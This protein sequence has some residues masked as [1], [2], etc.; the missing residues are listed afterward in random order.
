VYAGSGEECQLPRE[1][2]VKVVFLPTGIFF[3]SLEEELTEGPAGES[4][5]SMPIFPISLKI[6]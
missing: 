6:S 1:H 3:I 4:G 5:W 2:T